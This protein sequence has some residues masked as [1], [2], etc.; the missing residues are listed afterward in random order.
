MSEKTEKYE[1]NKCKDTIIQEHC[2]E[3]ERDTRHM[4]MTSYDY[5]GSEFDPHERWSI[6]WTSSHQVVQ[7]QGCMT[8]SFRK[9]SWFSEDVHQIGPDE[10]ENGERVILYPKRS[11]CTIA[12]KDYWE[13]PTNLRRI[14][15]ESIDCFNNDSLTLTAAGLRIIVE[16]LCAELEIEDGPKKIIPKGVVN[17]V[18]RSKNLDGKI[19]GLHEKGF[20]TQKNAEILHEHRYLGNT[21]VHELVQPSR[22]ELI[23]AINIIEHAFKTIFEIPMKGK[24]L[25]I[26]RTRRDKQT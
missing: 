2:V 3:C 16:G 6:D 7:C 12:T 26:K 23:L 20:L 19:N 4:I 1:E 11:N 13:I 17:E 8:L 14:Y 5:S 9:V 22:E 15:R 25:K 18:K 10:W 24:E 21:A